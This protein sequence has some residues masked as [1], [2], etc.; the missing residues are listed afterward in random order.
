MLTEK[1]GIPSAYGRETNEYLISQQIRDKKTEE[2]ADMVPATLPTREEAAALESYYNRTITTIGYFKEKNFTMPQPVQHENVNDDPKKDIPVYEEYIGDVPGT[3][4]PGPGKDYNERQK[5]PTPTLFDIKQAPANAPGTPAHKTG[6]THS[7][8]ENTSQATELKNT[9]AKE[10]SKDLISEGLNYNEIKDTF[11]LGNLQEI[12]D[13]R[14]EAILEEMKK[15]GYITQKEKEGEY[16]KAVAEKLKM[17]KDYKISKAV[18]DAHK[19]SKKPELTFTAGSEYCMG[20]KKKIDY[21][22]VDNYPEQILGEGS[23]SLGTHQVPSGHNLLTSYHINSSNDSKSKKIVYNFT[24]ED[25]DTEIRFEKENYSVDGNGLKAGAEAVG[26]KFFNGNIILKNA[27]LNDRYGKVKTLKISE[28]L[29]NPE[30]KAVKKGNS[31]T[32]HLNP[33]ETLSFES[34]KSVG[35]RQVFA[36]AIEF[37]NNKKVEVNIRSI[38]ADS[39]RFLKIDQAPDHYGDSYNSWYKSNLKLSEKHFN[40]IKN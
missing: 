27:L 38:S 6:A 16:R 23:K 37:S 11:A 26:E 24:A 5:I 34:E 7:E 30:K 22:I 28:E 33:G 13:K 4:T 39:D 25:K 40:D 36:S 15:S 20:Q 21:L 10:V 12:T 2:A 35:N 29:A 17:R 19:D 9:T 14:V 32:V 1:T 18:I 31:V 3:P 8:P